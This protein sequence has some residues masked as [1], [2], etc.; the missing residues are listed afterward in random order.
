[1]SRFKIIT[2]DPSYDEDGQLTDLEWLDIEEQDDE[3]EELVYEH[4]DGA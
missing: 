2:E 3:V 1:M 4:D